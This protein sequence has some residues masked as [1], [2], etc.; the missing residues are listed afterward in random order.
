M[1]AIH[2]VIYVLISVRTTAIYLQLFP[3]PENLTKDL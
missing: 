3:I 1:K 2:L